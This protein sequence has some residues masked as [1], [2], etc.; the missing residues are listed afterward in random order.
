MT[1]YLLQAI[2]KDVN[3]DTPSLLGLAPSHVV[4]VSQCQQ[5]YQQ[6][7]ILSLPTCI[8]KN[9]N[10]CLFIHFLWTRLV[11]TLLPV[12][13]FVYTCLWN[14]LVA[15]PVL[16]AAHRSVVR[17]Q[18]LQPTAIITYAYLIFMKLLL[19][20]HACYRAYFIWFL[21]RYTCTQNNIQTSLYQAH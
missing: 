5:N 13:V 2:R 18:R 4:G 10:L 12:N 11:V 20:K 21:S 7:S 15:A 3:D 1:S 16:V 6:A 9:C 19:R 8:F 17:D 14:R